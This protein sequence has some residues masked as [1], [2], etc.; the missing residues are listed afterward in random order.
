M[1]T[2]QTH[3]SYNAV[4]WQRTK[5]NW[6][7][8]PLIYSNCLFH[9]F[10][11]IARQIYKQTQLFELEYIQ[12]D[13]KDFLLYSHWVPK[14]I[15]EYP[16]KSW[17]SLLSWTSLD[18]VQISLDILG[19]SWISIFLPLLAAGGCWLW[20]GDYSGFH[21]AKETLGFTVVAIIMQWTPNTW[22]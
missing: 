15:L 8:Y 2:R 10:T 17:A 7:G 19:Y 14:D 3:Q 5:P 22:S 4:I 12:C 16:W 21:P 20:D 6:K 13:S 9:F 11:W 18:N 1:V